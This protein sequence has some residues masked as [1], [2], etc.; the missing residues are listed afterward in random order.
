MQIPQKENVQS[1]SHNFALLLLKGT[2]GRAIIETIFV[3]F[4]YEIYP[5]GYEN[6]Y[7]NITRY[8]RK[9][10]SDMTMTKIRAMPDLLVYDR[11]RNECYL[12]EIKTSSVPKE[13]DY[14]ISKHD[15][16]TY[17]KYWPEAILV[18]YCIQTTNIYCCKIQEIQP[19]KLQQEYFSRSQT[20][21]Y[22]L[23]LGDFS[24]LPAHFRRIKSQQYHRLRSEIINT[25]KAFSEESVC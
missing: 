14:W 9:S 2:I 19:N 16:D 13:S 5:Y 20:P 7:A 17:I 6:H 18:V 21:G 3:A 4:G 12:L 25:L 23:R 11:Q 22:I 1:R 10:D 15:L 24:S 8:I